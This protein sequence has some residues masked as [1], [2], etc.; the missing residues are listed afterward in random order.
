[1]TAKHDD[2]NKPAPV[3]PRH[4]SVEE[5][6]QRDDEKEARERAREES[7]RVEAA[8]APTAP[9]AP[10]KGAAPAK[11]D[12][13]DSAGMRFA[14]TSATME[15]FAAL[16][17]AQAD[18]VP[19]RRSFDI[20]DRVEGEIISIGPR[21]LFVDLGGRVE[22]SADVDH[23]RD[24]E[25]QIELEV[26]Q[27]A[28]FYVL[29]LKGGIHL[30]K[31][32]ART[33]G[34]IE[35]IETAFES[36]I[37]VKGRVLSTNKGGYEVE[38][39]NVR[40]FCPISQIDLAFTE[41]PAVHVGQ[42]YAFRVTEVREGGRT[43]VVSRAAVLREEQ[44]VARKELLANLREGDRLKGKVS[45]VTDYGAFVDI[46]GID[47]LVHV[48]ELSHV[49]FDRPTDVVREG[50]EVETIVL[51]IE[52]Q[53]GSKP[54]RIG[55]S[56]KAAESDPWM[57]ANE[58]FAVGQK[59]MGTV[60]RLMNFG[61]FV[62]IDRGLEGLVHVSEMSWDRHVATPSSV[63]SVGDEVQVEIQDIDILRKRIS[64]SM[65]GSENDPWRTI[66]DR[67]VVGMEVRGTVEKI[68]DFGAFVTLGKGITA[69]LPKSEMSL[70]R[71]AVV[72]RRFSPGMEV[73]A[74]V[75]SIEPTRRRMALTLKAAEDIPAEA[76]GAKES[77]A[78]SYQDTGS[79]GF[80]T[81]GDLLKKK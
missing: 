40:A 71:E 32:L 39:H 34:G 4:R 54:L 72:Q 29:S 37:P 80:G 69:L 43:V 65:K 2:K 1:M 55:L 59:V 41:D 27:R 44:E 76:G 35:A 10:Q 13:R 60:V 51:K 73:T 19:A 68:E 70:E 36:G 52:D 48:S 30:G 77:P 11:S 74:R 62:E 33:E 5:R 20:G 45:R 15:D 8:P 26:G 25:G 18:A 57:A 46:G 7:S 56:I 63:V 50:D 64:L 53:G 66:E 28:T 58:K 22:G 49:F 23:Y 16:F 12:P 78:T 79:K 42:T 24:E 47:G 9:S 3:P 14:D 38:I 61:A 21:Y 75:L 6:Q 17:E 67:Y 31:E 81:L